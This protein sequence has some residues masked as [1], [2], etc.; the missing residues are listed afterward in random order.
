MRFNQIVPDILR[1]TPCILVQEGMTDPEDFLYR[2][3]RRF[4]LLPRWIA[5]TATTG[6]SDAYMYFCIASYGY[7]ELFIR[8]GISSQK[9]VVTGIPNFDDC[10]A[11]YN[12]SFPFHNYVLVCTSDSRET[13]KLEDR[14]QFILDA[15][16]VA[17]GRQL[18]I[19][20]HPNEDSVRA[21][22]EIQR[23]A[24]DALV[25]TSGSAE[26]MVANCDV[27]IT[28]FSTLAFV[29]IA[30]GKETHSD[31]DLRS[32]RR[33][34]PVQHG[35]GARNIAAVCRSM[36]DAA[37]ASVSHNPDRA[38]AQDRI[39]ELHEICFPQVAEGVG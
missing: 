8:K 13:F 32:L 26:E 33:L 37:E 21:T 31:F 28:R 10:R 16:R 9:L 1:R 22:R 24:P 39:E 2:L 17:K 30:L 5:S 7:R 38:R 34:L 14:W 19:K 27:L 35:G 12:N 6:L 25:F 18:I 4:R 29:G 20:L 11:Y 23:N 15:V 3:A 36:L